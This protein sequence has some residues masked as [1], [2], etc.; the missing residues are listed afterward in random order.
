MV[1]HSEDGVSGERENRR[2]T[3]A[4][5]RYPVP[6]AVHRREA[7]VCGLAQE[8]ADRVHGGQATQIDR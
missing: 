3:G 2:Q 7:V 5:L 6:A 1:G 4:P 8:S